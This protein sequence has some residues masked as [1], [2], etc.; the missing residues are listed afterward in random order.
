MKI[1]QFLKNQGYLLMKN[2]L[3]QNSDINFYKINSYILDYLQK[4]LIELNKLVENYRLN[5][6]KLTNLSNLEKIEFY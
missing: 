3:N 2:R 1:E 5:L 6:S 4:S